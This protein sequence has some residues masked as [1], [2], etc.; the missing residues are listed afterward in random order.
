MLASSL[1]FSFRFLIVKLAEPRP[2][3]TIIDKN[4][5]DMEIDEFWGLHVKI[6]NRDLRSGIVFVPESQETRPAL[7]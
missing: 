3:W 1:G 5:S 7:K 6:Y 4:E 2:T